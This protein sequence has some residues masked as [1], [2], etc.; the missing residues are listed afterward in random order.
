M[1]VVI[2][3]QIHTNQVPVDISLDSL[4]R[5]FCSWQFW[6][7]WYLRRYNHRE[8]AGESLRGIKWNLILCIC[9]YVI[10]LNRLSLYFIFKYYIIWTVGSVY[11]PRDEI[12]REFSREL[13]TPWNIG[14][15]MY[16]IVCTSK[17]SGTWRETWCHHIPV[18]EL[19]KFTSL[20][21]FNISF[22][23]YHV[24]L[25]CGQGG[26]LFNTT[27]LVF[28]LFFFFYFSRTHAHMIITSFFIT[29]IAV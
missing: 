26:K 19:F 12:N 10:T 5:F 24:A 23:L 11:N 2:Y 9:M 8:I 13:R 28:D 18:I 21:F 20:I 7:L 1:I 16:V 15:Y 3:T 4:R 22:Q 29:T 27:I 25:Q 14:L 17:S 6:Q